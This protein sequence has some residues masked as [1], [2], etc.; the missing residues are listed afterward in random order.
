M[1]TRAGVVYLLFDLEND[2]GELTDVFA[3]EPAQAERLKRLLWQWM[4]QDPRMTEER[5]YLVPKRPEL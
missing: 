2:P 1:P 5:G 4:L 3:R